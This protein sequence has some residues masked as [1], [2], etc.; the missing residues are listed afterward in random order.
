MQRLI[1]SPLAMRSC[2]LFLGCL[3]IGALLCAFEKPA[4]AYVDPGSGFVVL[5]VVGSMM[6][7]AFFY[8]RHRFK[9]LLG[10]MRKSDQPEQQDAGIRATDPEL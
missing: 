6:A 4:H 3:E 10:L 2:L 1:R 7:G 8:L 5:Q 9:R